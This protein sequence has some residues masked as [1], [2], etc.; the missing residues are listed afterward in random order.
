MRDFVVIGAMALAAAGAR[1]DIVTN[2]TFDTNLVGWTWTPDVGS[3]P[4]M[5]PAVAP[6][7][8]GTGN[9]FRVNPGN[10]SGS[11]DLGGT[12]A[13]SVTLVGGVNYTVSGSLAIQ[14]VSG[15]PNADGGTITVRLG[16]TLLHTFDV[17]TINGA[18]T[19]TDPFS[20][21]FTPGVGGSFALEIRFTR[22]FANFVPNIY[23]W[24]DNIA[25]VPSPSGLA[26]L[27]MGLCLRRR[28]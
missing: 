15:G 24:A 13:Q 1:A 26:L 19:L 10:A 23:H 17:T 8:F 7:P 14:N 9:A 12:L 18:T 28:R 3:E 16:G 27:A 21:P 11:L 5:T 6:G 25:I 4:T 22:N 20:V 2:G